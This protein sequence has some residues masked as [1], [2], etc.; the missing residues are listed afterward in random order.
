VDEQEYKLKELR[1]DRGLYSDPGEI[2]RLE[3]PGDYPRPDIFTF[4]GDT[5]EF[6]LDSRTAGATLYMGLLTALNILL[7]RYAGQEDV[8]VG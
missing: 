6:S 7:H 5:L 2:P 4:A 1:E 3:L 8:I